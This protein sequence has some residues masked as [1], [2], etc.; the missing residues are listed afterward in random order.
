MINS[1]SRREVGG[2]PPT[3]KIGLEIYRCRKRRL[4]EVVERVRSSKIPSPSKTN[5][6]GKQSTS[7]EGGYCDC[8][9]GNAKGLKEEGKDRVC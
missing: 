9:Y 7:G 3:S 6:L 2:G 5:E 4:G 8:L 1:S